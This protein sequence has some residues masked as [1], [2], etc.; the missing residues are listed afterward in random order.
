[1]NSHMLVRERFAYIL[2][3]AKKRESIR[4]FIEAFKK[5]DFDGGLI[6]GVQAIEQALEG[7]QLDT[8]PL[9]CP[10][11]Y[12][13]R[14]NDWGRAVDHGN[15]LMIMLG[16]FGVLWCCGCWEDCLG[17]SQEPATRP[18]GRNGNAAA[19]HGSW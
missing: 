11:R 8:R 2:H 9:R 4:A 1:M 12:P 16:I 14:R 18:D 10:G 19:W 5:K 17:D 13:W 15:F 3:R 6:H 7:A